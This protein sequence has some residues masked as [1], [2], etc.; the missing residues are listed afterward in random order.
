LASREEKV[1]GELSRRAFAKVAAT[2]V[3]AGGVLTWMVGA[4]RAAPERRERH[5]HIHRALEELRETR[6]E[7]KDAAHDF[8]GHR[9]EALEAVDVA[10]R[11]LEVCLKFDRK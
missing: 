2:G 5:P 11:Q 10:I 9:A 6:R 4:L 8:G 3:L 1:M 7:L